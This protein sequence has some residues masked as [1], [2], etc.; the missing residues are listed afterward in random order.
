MTTTDPDL[1]EAAVAPAPTG[2]DGDPEDLARRVDE[3]VAAAT[4][5]DGDAGDVAAELR[6][7]LEEFHREGLVRLV[8]HLRADDRGRELL[9][10]LVDD[11]VV[12]TLFLLHGI[13]RPDPVVEAT[14]VLDTVRPYLQS[15]GGD[16]ELVEVVDGVARVRLH[17]SCNGCSMSAATLRDEVEAAL[18]N[19]VDAIGAVEV[20]PDEPTVAIIPV[21]AVVRR[22]TGWVDGPA[23]D[24]VAEGSMVRVDVG[25][26]SAVVVNVDG[27]LS[28]FRNA[29]AHQ[30]LELDG[31]FL[32]EGVIVCPWHGFRFEAT[33]GD[34]ISAPGAHLEALPLRIDDGVVRIRLG[35]TT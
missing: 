17:G 3:A 14:R 23:V 6:R 9:F 35:S 19:A 28:A 21:D 7:A 29:C 16:V 24:E 22:S 30:G 26:M 8:R 5:L 2:S 10:E 31:G 11:P 34:C 25:E 27:R 12:R 33:S 13:I 1:A 32:D 18:V 4:A 20:V 15:H